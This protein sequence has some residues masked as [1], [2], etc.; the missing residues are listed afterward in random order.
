MYVI[1]MCISCFMFLLMNYYLPFILYVFQTREM[2]LGKK[3]IWAI[4]LSKFK[5]CHK[6]AETTCNINRTFGPGTANKGKVQ[7]WF[8]KFCKGDDSFEDEEHSGQS[9]EVDSNQLRGS[10]KLVL[11]QLLRSCQRTQCWPFYS[12]LTFE[13]NWKGEKAQ[14]L[15]ASW[16]DCN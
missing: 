4:F 12:H 1:L 9:L 15:S 6:T 5:M 14:K 2:M 13:A 3:Q 11:L 16:T 8:K 10:S 7:W